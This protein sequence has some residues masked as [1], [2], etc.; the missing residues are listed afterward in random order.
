MKTQTGITTQGKIPEPQHSR[1]GRGGRVLGRGPLRKLAFLTVLLVLILPLGDVLPGMRRE[2]GGLPGAPDIRCR[3]CRFS[4]PQLW[5]DPRQTR[6]LQQARSVL[7]ARMP[8]RD[9][10]CPGGSDRAA[11]VSPLVGGVADLDGWIGSPRSLA[12]GHLRRYR[13]P[14]QPNDHLGACLSSI[15]RGR[16]GMVRMRSGSCSH[17]S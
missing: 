2:V 14:G 6:R 8:F 10:P 11:P 5:R 7:G 15:R 17:G 9:R 4:P 3:R 12:D 13:R 1:C 16:R